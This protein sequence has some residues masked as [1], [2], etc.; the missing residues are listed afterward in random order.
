MIFPPAQQPKRPNERLA[1]DR[2]VVARSG[3]L[4]RGAREILIRHEGQDY[5]LRITQQN[6]LILTK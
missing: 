6:K 5:R 4:F 3:E 1:L 2:T